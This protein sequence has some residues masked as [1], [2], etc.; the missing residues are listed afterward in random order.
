MRDYF[1]IGIIL[2][3]LPIGLLRPF[4]GLLFYTWISCMYPQELTW[5]FARTLPVAKLSAISVMAGLLLNRT[6]NFAVLRQRENI[7]IFIL[8]C[9][10]TTSSIFAFYP[11]DAWYKWQDVSKVL[12]MGTLAS[13]LLD[14]HRSEEHTSELQ[15]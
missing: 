8:W 1:I 10:F 12:L 4:Y 3:S 11:Q 7:S 13:I 9:T 15:S 2:A 6:N 14:D 5:S